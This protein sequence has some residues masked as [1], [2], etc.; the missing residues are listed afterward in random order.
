MGRE[1]SGAVSSDGGWNRGAGGGRPGE[2]SD[3]DV[4]AAVESAAG[5]SRAGEVATVDGTTAADAELGDAGVYPDPDPN[6]DAGP[7]P[8][9]VD[10]IADPP[11]G[12]DEADPGADAAEAR[13]AATPTAAA[14]GIGIGL[15]TVGVL[16]VV[17]R[18][19]LAAGASQF[20]ASLYGVGGLFVVGGFVA[21]AI[22]RA[23]DFSL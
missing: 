19:M 17:Y 21:H 18:T 6:P 2:A 23:D 20:V 12:D 3:A 8:A 10:G 22:R 9:P 13:P 14:V 1:Q 5:E 15:L 16:L 11:H 4:R 7:T